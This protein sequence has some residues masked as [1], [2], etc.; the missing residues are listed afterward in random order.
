MELRKVQMTGGSSFILTLPKDWADSVHLVKNEPL[1]VIVQP[2]GSLLVTKNLSQDTVQRVKRFH[3]SEIKDPVFLFRLLI[4][5]YIAGYTTVEVFSKTRLSTEARKAMRDFT[6]MTI[7]PEVTE[8]TDISIIAKDLLNP[9][10]MPLDKRMATI[11]KNMHADAILAL[12][13][14][15]LDLIDDIVNRDHDVNRLN[16]LVSRQ[17]N[18]ILRNTGI[19]KK[20]DITIPAVINMFLTSRIIERIG[21]HGVRIAENVRIVLQEDLDAE[22][23]PVIKIASIHSQKLFEKS[24]AAFFGDD[25]LASHRVI[26]ELLAFEKQCTKITT[27]AVKQK[28]TTAIAISNIAESIRRTGEY[29]AD[30]SEN[31]INYHVD[32]SG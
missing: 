22:I 12:E 31:A 28:V 16:W 30:V 29:S 19:A 23:V 1:A 27:F 3:A 13:T 11:V 26:E 24:L 17:K 14:K 25:S 2:D 7:G 9:T 20:L 32:T 5:A 21:Y 6:R 4:G 18:I 10:E 15:N 8:E